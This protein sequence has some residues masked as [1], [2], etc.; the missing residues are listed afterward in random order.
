VIEQIFDKTKLVQVN[1]TWALIYNDREYICLLEATS[2]EDAEQQ[3]AE[4]LFQ[5]NARPPAPR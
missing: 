1:G 3:I 5:K 4:M 2:R